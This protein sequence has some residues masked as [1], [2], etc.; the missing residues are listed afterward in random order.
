MTLALFAIL[1]GCSVGTQW[2]K[3]ETIERTPEIPLSCVPW[4]SQEQHQKESQCI[5]PY[6]FD[7]KRRQECAQHSLN[8][9]VQKL[10]E[11]QK[12]LCK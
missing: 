4:V 12:S 8:R 5:L 10:E 6:Y 1:Q 9:A 11:S 3:E 2:K 7:L